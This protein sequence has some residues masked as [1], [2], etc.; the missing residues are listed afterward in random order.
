MEVL[1]TPD[2][3]FDGLPDYDFAP[4][5]REVTA[6]DGTALRYHFIDE[7]PRDADPILLLHGN[8]SWSFYYRN[9]IKALSKN[10]RVIALD[11]IGM[12][13]SDKPG[14]DKYTYTAASRLSDLGALID[15]LGIK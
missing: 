9:L 7:G 14:E 12:G 15:H 5:Y 3:C 6:E 10:Y 2:D 4:H 13:L 11:H 1:R 8:P